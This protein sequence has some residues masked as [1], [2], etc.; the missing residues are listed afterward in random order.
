M[1]L[2]LLCLTSGTED[3]IAA[4]TVEEFANLLQRIRRNELEAPS[5]SNREQTHDNVVVCARG[6]QGSGKFLAQAVRMSEVQ[7]ASNRG[8]L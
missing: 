7:D 5:T 4:L 2:R 8:P 3:T 1:F 6:P